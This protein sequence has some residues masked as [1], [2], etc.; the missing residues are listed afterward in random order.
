MTRSLALLI[1]A[2]SLAAAAAAPPVALR[3]CPSDREQPSGALCGEIAVPENRAK[4]GGRQIALSV[5]VLPGRSPSAK[6]DPVFGVAG[7][8]GAAGTRLAIAY[9]RLYDMLQNDHDIVLV[10]QRGT[11]GS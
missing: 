8:P 4:T 3:P 7:G 10:D 2:A 6:T 1:A 5:V 11:G 9:P